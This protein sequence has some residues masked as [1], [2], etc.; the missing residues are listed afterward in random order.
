MAAPER[1]VI[2]AGSTDGNGKYIK[3]LTWLLYWLPDLCAVAYDHA[4]AE[5]GAKPLAVAPNVGREAPAFVRFIVDHYDALPARMVFLHGDRSAWH[6]RDL[7][8][9]LRLLRW[10]REYA[11]LNFG[12]KYVLD[13]GDA[14]LAFRYNF[15][16]A[17]KDRDVNKAIELADVAGYPARKAASAAKGKLRGAIARAFKTGELAIP[18]D[19]ADQIETGLR[20]AL[21]DRLT[22]HVNILEMNGDS[23]RLGQSR[24]RNAEPST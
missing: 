4:D 21:L 11:N 14:G 3:D 16:K 13:P 24:A 2:V 20:R 23:Y 10:E 18:D 7:V 19:L 6:D 8:T 1:M 9:V 22:H 5:D 12:S 17:V 15:I